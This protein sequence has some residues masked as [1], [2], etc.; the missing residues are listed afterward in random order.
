[1]PAPE[2]NRWME[3]WEITRS[4]KEAARIGLREW[5]EAVKAE[6]ELVWQTPAVRY[7]TFL[8]GALIAVIAV[9]TAID[10]LQPVDPALMTP[11]AKTAN[12]DVI[13]SNAR[14]GRH[15]IIERKFKFRKF[16]V[17]CPYCELKTGQ[18]ALRCTSKT[19]RSKLV[20]TVRVDGQ[21]HCADCRAPLGGGS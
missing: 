13:C 10:M 6:P 3:W 20:L 17:S 18:R 16:P 19:C 8:I 2:R 12:F 14:C 9:R 1:M 15:F 7:T 11:L 4:R 5:W 21:V